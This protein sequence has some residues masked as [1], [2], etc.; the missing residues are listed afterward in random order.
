MSTL[1]ERLRKRAE[2]EREIAANSAVVAGLL[3]P[4]LDRFTN[5]EPPWNTYAVRVALDHRNSAKK[6]AE[7]ADDLEEA[8]RLIEGLS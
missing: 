7:F 2:E 8:I 6:D 1:V 4:Q 5:R 3:K